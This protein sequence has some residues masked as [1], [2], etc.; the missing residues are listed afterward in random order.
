MRVETGALTLICISAQACAEP[1]G[2]MQQ[3]QEY[4]TALG[5][6]ATCQTSGDSM[7]MRT[8]ESS[9]VADF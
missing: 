9:I 4:L 5:T 7:E 8:A 3:E 6:A 1:E 2:S